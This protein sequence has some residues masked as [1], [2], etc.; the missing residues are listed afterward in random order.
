MRPKSSRISL[1]SLAWIGSRR[2]P[3]PAAM[4]TAAAAMLATATAMLDAATAML[5]TATAMLDAATAARPSRR[6]AAVS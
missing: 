5:A 2:P 1:P 6:D 3:R 4:L